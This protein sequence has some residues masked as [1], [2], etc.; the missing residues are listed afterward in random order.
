MKKLSIG[1]AI[2]VALTLIF[3]YG[4]QYL[5]YSRINQ[6]IELGDELPEDAIQTGHLVLVSS[7]QLS[8]SYII[9]RGEHV[10]EVTVHIEVRDGKVVSIIDYISPLD[11]EFTT[12]EGI[13]VG[14]SFEKVRRVS[15]EDVIR[16][17][18][19]GFYAYIK[20]P[21]G[22]GAAFLDKSEFSSSNQVVML[23]KRGH[24]LS[25]IRR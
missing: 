6:S 25:K 5:Q 10:Y 22:W 7:A 17:P 18:G 3:Q 1:I 11:K 2:G 4:W 12:P 8:P 15:K 20:L 13:R 9:M 23:F 19:W 24:M 21:S 16:E 14:D